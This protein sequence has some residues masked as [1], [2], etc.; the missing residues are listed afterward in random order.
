MSSCRQITIELL[1]DPKVQEESGIDYETY[2]VLRDYGG[3]PE[4][5]EAG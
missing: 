1:I 4:E 2:P 5:G 3:E